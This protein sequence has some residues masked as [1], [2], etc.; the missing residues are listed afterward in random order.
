MP[1]AHVKRERDGLS[2]RFEIE[3]TFLSSPIRE[4]PVSTTNSG[5]L[6]RLIEDR[7]QFDWTIVEEA[8]K[9]TGPEL[10][11]PQL[12]SMRRHLIGDHNQL[13]PFNTDRVAITLGAKTSA[14][15]QKLPQ[16]KSQT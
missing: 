16:T 12:L 2:D 5:D 15:L 14:Q 9:A 7:A 10:L 11:A 6:E 8:A 4:C 13:P 3:E 1:P